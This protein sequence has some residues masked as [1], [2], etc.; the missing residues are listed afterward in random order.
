MKDIEGKTEKVKIA[1]QIRKKQAELKVARTK[2]L[3]CKKFVEPELDFNRRCE[4]R[5]NLRSVQK[6]GS[7]LS[8][9]YY[10]LQK[11]NILEPTNK[12]TR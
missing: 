7:I 9:R 11:R 4:L 6:A 10:S 5:G 12:V 8:E 1:A 2:R 3:S